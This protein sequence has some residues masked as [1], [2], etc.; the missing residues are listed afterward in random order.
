MIQ[1]IGTLDEEEMQRAI[2][3]IQKDKKS[4][5]ERSQRKKHIDTE[6]CDGCIFIE[7]QRIGRFNSLGD[8]NHSCQK[9]NLK[10]FTSYYD[11]NVYDGYISRCSKCKDEKGKEITKDGKVISGV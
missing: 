7:R 11:G 9:Y 1:L 8:F 3:E 6:R 2:D 10:L 5:E 4:S